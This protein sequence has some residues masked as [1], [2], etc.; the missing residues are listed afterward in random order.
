MLRNVYHSSAIVLVLGVEFQSQRVREEEGS[1]GRLYSLCF[2]FFL[3]F[4][5]TLIEKKRGISLLNQLQPIKV[6]FLTLINK[7]SD[8]DRDKVKLVAFVE[9]FK[10]SVA[11]LLEHFGI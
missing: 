1:E 8:R 2:D 10:S 7:F 11:I 6:A 3:F 5:R 4:F 9:N